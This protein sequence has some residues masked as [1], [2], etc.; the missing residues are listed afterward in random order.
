MAVDVLDGFLRALADDNDPVPEAS[1]MDEAFRKLAAI[2][3]KCEIDLPE[4]PLLQLVPAP[5][6]NRSTVRISVSLRKY[7][8]DMIDRKAE[9]AGMTRGAF[10]VEAA[11]AYEP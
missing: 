9:E 5:D 3:R 6:L 2:C 11:G 8:L 1:D 10:L 7:A 4:R